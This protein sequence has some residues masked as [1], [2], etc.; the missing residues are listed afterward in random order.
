M[1]NTQP[2]HIDVLI[3]KTEKEG[4]RIR[5]RA[6]KVSDD[7]PEHPDTNP[8]NVGPWTNSFR[9]KV[10][11]T[12]PIWT[13]LKSIG[14]RGFEPPTLGSQNRCATGLRY[15]PTWTTENRQ[16]KPGE[17]TPS[18]SRLQAVSPAHSLSLKLNSTPH[19]PENVR[20]QSESGPQRMRG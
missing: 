14:V 8:G 5:F 15:T 11:P 10:L 7:A 19:W 3:L 20:Y 4:G 12:C 2:N 13:M 17:N 16:M 18:S 9:S 6:D 1:T